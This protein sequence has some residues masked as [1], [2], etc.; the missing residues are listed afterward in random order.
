MVGFQYWNLIDST[1][2]SSLFTFPRRPLFVRYQHECFSANIFSQQQI[3]IPPNG[4]NQDDPGHNTFKV[5]R[6]HVFDPK[7]WLGSSNP[8]HG[9]KIEFSKIPEHHYH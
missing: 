7:P 3:S 8:S 9:R 2:K 1:T 6:D 4:Y 5:L